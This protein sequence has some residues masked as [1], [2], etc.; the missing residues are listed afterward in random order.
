MG[1]QTKLFPCKTFDNNLMATCKNK[2]TLTFNKPA[3]IGISILE[4][5]KLLMYEFHYD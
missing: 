4:L 5:T 2:V 1:I 3:Y